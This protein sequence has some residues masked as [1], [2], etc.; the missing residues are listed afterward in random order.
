[1]GLVLFLINFLGL[2]K[3]APVAEMSWVSIL[4]IAAGILAYLAMIFIVILAPV[5][6]LKPLEDGEEEASVGS[7]SRVMV[8]EKDSPSKVQ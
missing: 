2:F 5:S 8:E 1:M 7:S 6:E 3:D 4:L